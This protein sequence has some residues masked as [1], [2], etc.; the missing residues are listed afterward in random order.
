MWQKKQIDKVTKLGMFY[1]VPSKPKKFNTIK[2]PT[3]NL[4]YNPS[5]ISQKLMKF[6]HQ[7]SSDC[8]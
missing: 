8:K 4:N 3:L 6:C 5:N 7:I 1:E 2:R